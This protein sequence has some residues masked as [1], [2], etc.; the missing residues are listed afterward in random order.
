M[1]Q[2]RPL[3]QNSWLRRLMG[4]SMSSIG[5]NTDRQPRYDHDFFHFQT[6]IN[7]LSGHSLND[8]DNNCSYYF[9]TIEWLHYRSKNH[10]Q[11]VPSKP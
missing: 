11:T 5:N 1:C 7:A 4:E 3:K 10:W 2:T 9:W 6:M 8:S